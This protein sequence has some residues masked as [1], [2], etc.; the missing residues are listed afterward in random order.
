LKDIVPVAPGSL[1]RG[2]RRYM[3]EWFSVSAMTIG[4]VAV[5]CSL[6]AALGVNRV[7]RCRRRQRYTRSHP[8]SSLEAGGKGG[9][10]GKGQGGVRAASL[11]VVDQVDAKASS[12]YE[13]RAVG[14]VLD[15]AFIK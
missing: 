2:W 4:C 15:R 13:V 1:R 10:G 5:C 6:L 14:G 8:I 9:G 3:A 7:V 11:Q 12:I